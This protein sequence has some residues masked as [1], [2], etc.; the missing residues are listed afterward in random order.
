MIYESTCILCGIALIT[1]STN[2]SWPKRYCDAEECQKK[3]RAITKQNAREKDIAGYRKKDR[4]YKLAI[5][6]AGSVP[7]LAIC[8]DCK[9]EFTY[10]SEAELEANEARSVVESDD[11]T[12]PA[13]FLTYEKCVVLDQPSDVISKVAP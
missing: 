11:H 6:H 12:W 10:K 8:A 2:S 4:E 9:V 7:K 1:E 5:N 3:R 13:R